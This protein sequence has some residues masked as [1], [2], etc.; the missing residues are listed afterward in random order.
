MNRSVS[1]CLA[2]IKGPM[3]TEPL[4]LPRIYPMIWATYTEIPPCCMD[5]F[6]SIIL[7]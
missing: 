4:R 5:G 3:V 7:S 2:E 6:V 1:L